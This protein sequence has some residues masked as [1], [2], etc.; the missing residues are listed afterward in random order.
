MTTFPFLCPLS[1]YLC[2]STIWSIGQRLSITDLSFPNSQ[3]SLRKLRSS[4]FNFK[5][6]NVHLENFR[7]SYQNQA[8][9]QS[10]KTH[11]DELDLKGDFSEKKFVLHAK[12]TAKINKAKSKNVT[13]ISNKNIQ[14]DLDL[15]VDQ[16]QN[17]IT[18]PASTIQIANLPFLFK[19]E[20]T[21][22]KYQFE[23]HSNQFILRQSWCIRSCLF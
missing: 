23:I 16:I 5:L 3:S 7:F 19:G 22:E 4:A 17:T 21:P 9:Q 20:V 10:Y 13:L 12:T 11:I 2:A 8:I 18:F 15:I 1:T 14:F 6:E